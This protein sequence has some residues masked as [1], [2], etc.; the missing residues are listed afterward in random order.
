MAR[1]VQLGGRYLEAPASMNSTS[2]SARDAGVEE[3]RPGRVDVE[4]EAG[5][6]AAADLEVVL[7][8]EARRDAKLRQARQRGRPRASRSISRGRS[9]GRCP[10]HVGDAELARS[11]DDGPA[12]GEPTADLGPGAAAGRPGRPRPRGSGSGRPGRSGCGSCKAA[13]S[14]GAPGSSRAY[15]PI[16]ASSSASPSAAPTPSAASSRH[17]SAHPATC[18]L[19]EPLSWASFQVSEQQYSNSRGSRP[20]DLAYSMAPSAG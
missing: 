19:V 4:S 13:A 15:R 1:A 18:S 9:A 8:V 5:D 17:A 7:A 3:H 14:A 2:R 6:L 12:A 16:R 20:R 11:H 10:V